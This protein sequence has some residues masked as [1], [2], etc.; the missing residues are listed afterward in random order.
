VTVRDWLF[1]RIPA[2]PPLE[3][4]LEAWT[5]NSHL[6]DFVLPEFATEAPLS[7]WA[8]MRV[9]AVARGRHLTC[10]AIA[11]CPLEILAGP[12]LVTPQPS[13]AF[14]TDGQTGDLDASDAVRWKLT[15]Q[16][17]WSRMLWTVD[18][19]V[20]Y[21]ES[22]WY[23][24]AVDVDGRPTRL[25]RMPYEAWGVNEAG[26]IVDADAHPLE[27][28]RL[29]YFP[30]PHEGLLRFGARTVKQAS[31]LEQTSADVAAHPFRLELHQTTG[32]TLTPEERREV[33]TEARSALAASDGVLFTN[34]ALETKEHRM[35]SDSLL[36]GG[37][38]AAALD[39]ARHISMPGAMLDATTEGSSLEYQTATARNQ[40]WIDYGLSLYMGAVESRLGMDDVI[41]RGQRAAFDTADLTTPTAAPT[42]PPTAD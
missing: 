30:G 33:V 42:G 13:W 15:A 22:L 35:D 41:P 21:G 3:P 10:S 18:D 20:F 24:T 28:D 27:V 36:I 6:Y 25:L 29:V 9:P 40:Q 37:R 5:D 11:G 31:S 32:A 23:S 39:V 16:A 19:L 17:P 26:V 14:A 4:Q 8:A 1:P 2:L 38:N 12:D 7:R 34:A